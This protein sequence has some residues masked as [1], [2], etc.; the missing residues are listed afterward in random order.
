MVGII[1]YLTILF[2][3]LTYIFLTIRLYSNRII[4]NPTKFSVS[5]HKL[6]KTVHP[7]CVS[8]SISYH[9]PVPTNL[10]TNVT[11]VDVKILMYSLLFVSLHGWIF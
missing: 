6:K 9:L 10:V 5:E 11:I 3:S 8:S 2:V 1:I 7:C 4:V